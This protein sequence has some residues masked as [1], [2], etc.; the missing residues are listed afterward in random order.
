MVI[1]TNKTIHWTTNTLHAFIWLFMF[2]SHFHC[3]ALKHFWPRAKCFSQMATWVACN[4]FW[5]P[6]ASAR[7]F[8]WPLEAKPTRVAAPRVAQAVAV[9]GT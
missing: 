5:R 3:L 6:P 8:L 7:F 1:N 4:F 2:S 9:K